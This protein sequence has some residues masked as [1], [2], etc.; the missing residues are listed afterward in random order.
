MPVSRRAIVSFLKTPDE[1][2]TEPGLL[3]RTLQTAR[4]AAN[5]PVPGP[6]RAELLTAIHLR[7]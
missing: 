4:G 1:L 6:S 2:F 5:Y 7:S 3:D